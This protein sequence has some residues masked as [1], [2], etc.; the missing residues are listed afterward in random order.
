MLA[1][2][3]QQAAQRRPVLELHVELLQQCQHG[4][5]WMIALQCA[6]RRPRFDIL[7]TGDLQLRL[8]QAD[9]QRGFGFALA[10]LLQQLVALCV[11]AQLVGCRAAQ[12][13]DQRLTIPFRSQLQM[14]ERRP[15]LPFGKFAQATPRGLLDTALTMAT[16]PGIDQRAGHVQQPKRSAPPAPATTDSQSARGRPRN[17]IR[18]GSGHR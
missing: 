13:V 7:A 8:G 10:S 17:S 12:V 9:R 11:L 1:Q 5:P 2:L 4:V 6:E 14:A 18:S 3:R 15:P 16:R